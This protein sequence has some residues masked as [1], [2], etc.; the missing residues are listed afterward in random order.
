MLKNH[1]VYISGFFT[2]SCGG[3]Y[4]VLL[5]S[6]GLWA[7]VLSLP[8]HLQHFMQSF[9]RI[10]VFSSRIGSVLHQVAKVLAVNFSP[11]MNISN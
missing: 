8:N 4:P 11:S 9:S 10:R 5:Y 1:V 3:F 7:C 6:L 2:L